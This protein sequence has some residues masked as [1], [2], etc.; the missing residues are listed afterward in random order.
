[1][2][3]QIEG[4]KMQVYKADLHIHTPASKCYK[5]CKDDAEY[6]CATLLQVLS[7]VYNIPPKN[8]TECMEYKG[9]LFEDNN[10]NENHSVNSTPSSNSGCAGMLALM[11][12]I[13]GASVYGIVELIS[14]FIA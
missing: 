9:E 7:Q 6:C 5:G 3:K 14:R 13:G 1:M 4:S 2:E 11:L 8:A 12:G 10:Y